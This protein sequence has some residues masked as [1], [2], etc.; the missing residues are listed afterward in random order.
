MRVGDLE[1]RTCT[2]HGLLTEGA[3]ETG[4]IVRWTANE[5]GKPWYYTLASWDCSGEEPACNFAGGKPFRLEQWDTFSMLLA[6]GQ[7]HL[8]MAMKLE[9]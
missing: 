3:L 4:E 5:E 7:K 1:F 6:Y 2:R 9:R 8:D